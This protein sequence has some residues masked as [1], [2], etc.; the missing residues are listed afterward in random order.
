MEGKEK[1][2]LLQLSRVQERPFTSR[3]PLVGGPVAWLRTQWNNVATKGYVRPLLAQQNDFNQLLVKQ[4]QEH[5]AWLIDQ[6]QEQASLI[7]EIA[8]ITT[9][10]VHLKRQLQSLEQRLNR[11]EIPAQEGGA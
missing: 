5:D 4:L 7:H 6:D 10:A 8:V 1:D 9:R 11:L 2:P 3:L